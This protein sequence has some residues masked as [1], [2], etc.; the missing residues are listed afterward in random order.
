MMADAKPKSNRGRKPTLTDS[1][2]RRKK[3]ETNALI[4]RS[5]LYV[6]EQYDRWNTLKLTLRLQTHAE[7]AKVLLDRYEQ[8]EKDFVQP[9]LQ[10]RN[11]AM[12]S[13]DLTVKHGLTSTPGILNT[14]STDSDRA[15][16]GVGALPTKRP[17]VE[18]SKQSTRI[19]QESDKKELLPWT[20]DIMNHFWYAAQ[21]SDTYETF[22]GVWFGLLH[23]V[24]DEHEWI[25]PFNDSGINA[26]QHGPLTE[27]RTK[28]WL[29]KNSPAHNALR[30]VVMDKR[31]LNQI[32]YY[33]NCRSTAEL[34]NFQ[35]SILV[36]ASK[37]FSYSPPTYRARNLLA[38]LDHNGH[39]ERE[40]KINKD[41]SVRYQ[42]SFNKKTGIW[43]VHELK[44]DKTYSYIQSLVE[45]IVKRRLNDEGMSGNVVLEADDPRRISK[46]LARI[47]PPP[48]AQ[49][50]KERKSRF[51]DP[52]KTF[53][54]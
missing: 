26:C 25:L 53:D 15:I 10:T 5:R 18:K 51:E 35:N 39:A 42:R 23:H 28:G 7:V 30:Y 16:S 36:Y 1:G 50:V 4:N 2:R 9:V 40:I 11:V 34:E 46:T 12:A 3:K 17:R 38:A 13:P 48:T 29:E 31:R 49:L 41:G 32:H 43:S 19:A 44:G 27:E 14:D 22:I 24:T 37:R 20:K 47:P 33:L 45:K 8:S 6:G 21:V 54:Y 52:D